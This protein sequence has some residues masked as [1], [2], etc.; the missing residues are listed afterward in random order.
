MF[1]Y[2]EEIRQEILSLKKQYQNEKK[3]KDGIL[4]KKLTEE[5]KA[6]NAKKEVEDNELIKNFIKDK[7]K[8]EIIKSNMP[9]KGVGR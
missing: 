7:E 8:Y 1:S 9:L 4:E 6:R 2:R 3:V 5:V